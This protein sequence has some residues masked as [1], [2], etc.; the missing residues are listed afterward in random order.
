MT[1]TLINSLS[2]DESSKVSDALERTRNSSSGVEPNIGLVG[3]GEI[4]KPKTEN[5]SN[6]N[7]NRGY[8]LIM[9]M[10]IP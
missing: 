10:S 5:T 7:F 1:I 3:E 6:E 8:F 9:E 2:R 4:F